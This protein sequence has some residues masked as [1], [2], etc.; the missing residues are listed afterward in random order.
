MSDTPRTDQVELDQM[1]EFARTLE[2]ELAVVTAERNALA[3]KL[4]E[5]QKDTERMDRLEESQGRLVTI[6]RRIL[7]WN[8]VGNLR[9]SIDAEC[10][11][12]P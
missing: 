6:V 3:A 11:K 12:Q 4:V 8:D 2:R 10:T 5:A 7:D 9:A 1:D